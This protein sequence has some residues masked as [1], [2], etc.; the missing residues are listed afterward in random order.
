MENFIKET[1]KVLYTMQQLLLTV[2]NLNINEP[3]NIMIDECAVAS[4]FAIPWWLYTRL[5][6]KQR[7]VISLF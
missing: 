6:V 7:Y 4:Y 2:I 5:T 3:F 1:R